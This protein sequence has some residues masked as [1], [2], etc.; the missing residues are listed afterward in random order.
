MRFL[1]IIFSIYILTLSVVPCSDMIN[2]CYNKKA[3]IEHSQNHNH[4]QD[5]DDNCTPFC[6]CTC[7][8]S[9]ITVFTLNQI[10]AEIQDNFVL[11][12]ETLSYN[13]TFTSSFYRNIWQPPK[14]S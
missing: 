2:E 7:C 12:P 10:V 4:N 11:T 9:G 1:T 8:V 14:L 13:S 6:N 3:K 5:K